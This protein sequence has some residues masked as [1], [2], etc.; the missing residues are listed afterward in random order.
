[1]LG[2]RGLD[3]AQRATIVARAAA[4][5]TADPRLDG[6]LALA[7]EPEV[8]GASMPVRLP[9]LIPVLGMAAAM[10]LRGQSEAERY[11]KAPVRTPQE[12]ADCTRLA[13]LLIDRGRTM[14][15]HLLGRRLGRGLG[16]SEAR[17]EG[18]TLESHR[19]SQVLASPASKSFLDFDCAQAEHL[20]RRIEYTLGEGELAWARHRLRATPPT[21]PLAPPNPF[22]VGPSAV[23]R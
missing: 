5:K 15:E 12:R 6:L 10:P 2:T 20:D 9:A 3:D 21:E 19:L 17:V 22:R 11:C 16:W 8:S 23:G 18:L 14:S 7:T 4:A 1:M 13:D